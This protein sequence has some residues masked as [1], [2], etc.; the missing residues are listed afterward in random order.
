MNTLMEVSTEE[1]RLAT[2]VEKRL[3]KRVRIPKHK[4]GGYITEQLYQ[5]VHEVCEIKNISLSDLFQAV[6]S[7]YVE[8]VFYE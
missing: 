6:L 1:R 5:K 4:I 3:Q 8:S 7:E 2:C